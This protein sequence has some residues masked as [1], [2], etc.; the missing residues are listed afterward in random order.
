MAFLLIPKSLG[1][2]LRFPFA[3]AQP[4]SRAPACSWASWQNHCRPVRRGGSLEKSWYRS[5]EKLEAEVFPY[6]MGGTDVRISTAEE[7]CIACESG[8]L[9]MRPHWGH[10]QGQGDHVKEL[11][12][13]VP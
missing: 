9:A 3:W 8:D 11:S 6:A 5:L 7:S 12:C 13:P 4:F 10:Q 2:Y 1:V